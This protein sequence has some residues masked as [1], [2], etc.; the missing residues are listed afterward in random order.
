MSAPIAEIDPLDARRRQATGATL[1]DLREDG[2]RAAGMAE[3]ALGLAMAELLAEPGRVLADPNAEILLICASG[4]RSLVAAQALAARGYTRLRSVAGGTQRWRSDGLPMAAATADPDFIDRY[5]RHLLLPDVGLAGQLRL[6]S[7]RIALVGAGGLG[8]P[9]A[10]YLAAAGVGRIRLIDDDRIERSNLQRQVLHRDADIGRA[11]AASGRDA[12]LALNPS[13]EVEAVEQ[14]LSADNV[15][16]LLGD[17]DLV[18]DGADNFPTRYLI[19]D[20]CVRLGLPMVYGAVQRFAG[21]VAVFWPG[22]PGTPGSCYRCLFP[23]PPAPEFAPNCAEAG[24]LGVL[25]GVI[26]ML[27]ATEAI[28]LLLGIGEPLVDRLLRFDALRM[29]FDQLQ[30]TRDPECVACGVQGGG[31]GYAELAPVCAGPRGD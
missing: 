23:E 30:L 27:Q 10:L 21:Q 28:K 29:R 12:L 18:L 20:A 5:S 8:S 31:L 7:A 13:I 24:V 25:P 15:E 2:E 22:R 17:H 4:R 14:R 16:R 11:K 19:S 26:G 9:A 6:Q 1:L 3:G